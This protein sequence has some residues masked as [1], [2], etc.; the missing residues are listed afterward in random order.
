[1]YH[2]IHTSNKKTLEMIENV[3]IKA[4]YLGSDFEE[5][6]FV[7]HL[8]SPWPHSIFLDTAIANI[9]DFWGMIDQF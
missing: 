4:H 9:F 7:G 8:A 6:I 2:T 1:M 5:V 3:A